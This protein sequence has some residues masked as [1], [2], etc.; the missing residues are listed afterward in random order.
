MKRSP[1][2]RRGKKAKEWEVAKRKG[3]KLLENVYGCE[4]RFLGC[5]GGLFLGRAHRKKRRFCDSEELAIYC[6]ACAQCHQKLEVL[7]PEKMFA[8]VNDAIQRRNL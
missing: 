6:V 8:L 4:V 7:P 2:N 3:D 1:L 5:L